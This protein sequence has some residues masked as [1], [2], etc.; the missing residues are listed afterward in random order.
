[1][2]NKHGI[3]FDLS[4][5]L[6]IHKDVIEKFDWLILSGDRQYST[7]QFSDRGNEKIKHF[8]SFT[9]TNGYLIRIT[10]E[11]LVSKFDTFSAM[12]V[13]F[14]Y[15]CTEL[16]SNY[17]LR[18]HSPHCV[19][20][21]PNAPWHNK[22]HRHEFDGKIKRID[23]YS[24]DHRPEKDRKKKYTWK[25]FPVELHFLNNE[26]WPFVSEFLEEVSNL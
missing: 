2:G 3:W 6:A 11:T 17:H 19:E 22:H 16:S 7:M 8:I 26:D 15:G 12:T 24:F 14:N 9:T 21:N 4:T 20:Y 18:Y 1:M 5:H 23:I 25:G 13:D 10:K